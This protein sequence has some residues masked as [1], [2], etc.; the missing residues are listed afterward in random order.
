[1]GLFDNFK[2]TDVR[3]VETPSAPVSAD[4]LLH[5]MEWGDFLS[6]GAVMDNVDNAIGKSKR[7]KGP[8]GWL[9]HGGNNAPAGFSCPRE[10]NIEALRC[11]A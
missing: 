7:L 10:T 9:G 2:K 4:D 5:I 8:H 11:S 1:M 3:S 6:D